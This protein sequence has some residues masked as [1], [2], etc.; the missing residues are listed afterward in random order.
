MTDAASL[1]LLNHDLDKDSELIFRAL[2]DA[3]PLIVWTANAN[4]ETDYYNSQWESYTGFTTE[5]TKGWGWSPV[6]H[7]DD[8]QNC[9]EKWIHTINTGEPYEVEYRFKRVSDG[10]YRWHLGRATPFKDT[11]GNIIKWFGICTDI[12]DQVS[13]KNLLNQAYLE[14]EK[15]VAERTTELAT[16]NQ[17][18]ARHNE[19]RKAAVEALQ[20]DSARLNEIITTQTILAKANLDLNAFINLVVERMAILTQATGA[21]VEMAEGDEM[22]Y[23]AAAGTLSD[24]IG[25]RLN[26]YTSLSGLCIQ[27]RE[28]LNCIDT[29]NDPRVNIDACRAIGIRAMVVAPLFDGGNPVGV[30]KIVAPEPS[31]F[32]DRDLQTLRLMAGLIGAAIGH[33][34]DYDTNLR[35]LSERT[36][37]VAA[38]EHEIAR[39]I[40]IEEA[41]RENELRTRMILES[42]YDAFIAMDSNGI[43]IDWNQQAEVT[44]GWARQEAIGTILGDLIIPERF[45]QAHTEGMKKFVETGVG[46]VLGKRIELIGLRKNGAEFPL[47]ITIRALPT[48]HGHEFCSFLRDI[49]EQKNAEKH[50]FQLAH[51]DY[52]TNL[53]NRSLFNDRIIEAMQRSKRTRSLMALMYLDVDKF[54]SINDNYGHAV[55]DELLIE[56]SKR[57]STAVRATDTV[58]R[59]GGDEFTIIAESLK[60][61]D[62]AQLIASKIIKHVRREMCIHDHTLNITTSIGVSFYQ[63]EDINAD[64]LIN[65]ADRALYRAKQAGRNRMSV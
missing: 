36:E 12:D 42:S 15:I 62:D 39:R 65:N 34:T 7:P 24:H 3:I 19:I 6:L 2:A 16:A 8:L 1:A 32:T 31:S 64:Q 57:L 4:G 37:A 18:L 10:A 21:V 60:S 27:S 45:R 33:Q 26:K 35:L 38:L 46:E 54:K 61:P 17:Q 49:T 28:V 14:V 25:L 9:M 51:S 47:E 63:G 11:A 40:E 56:F 29:E 41:V 53:P 5:Q 13:A 44:F 59:L 23:I 58:A 50:L 22:V 52:L 43:I 30:L 20:R 48:K 55:G